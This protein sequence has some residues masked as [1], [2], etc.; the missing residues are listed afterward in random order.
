MVAE[1]RPLTLT[2]DKKNNKKTPGRNSQGCTGQR[3]FAS[4]RGGRKF[5]RVGRCGAGAKYSRQGWAKVK[6]GAFSGQGGTV[7][8]ICGAGAVRG[9]FFSGAGAGQ[10]RACIPGNRKQNSLQN[11]T[12]HLYPFN[13][14]HSI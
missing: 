2:E 8:K 5:F 14:P 13:I 10:D 12:V 9:S 7:L 1:R 11:N 6:L 4:G 3:L